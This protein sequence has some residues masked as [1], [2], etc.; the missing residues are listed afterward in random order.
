MSS[1]TSPYR[2]FRRSTRVPLK[3][4]IESSSSA[5]GLSFEGETIVVN[6][7]GALISTPITLRVGMPIEIHVF[8]TDKRARAEVV[9]LDPAQPLQCGIELAKPQNIW[10]VSLP[11]ED[12]HEDVGQ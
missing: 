3:I 4:R 7:H 1:G 11:P 5:E 8:L 2:R 12:W 6:L 10:G 9:Y